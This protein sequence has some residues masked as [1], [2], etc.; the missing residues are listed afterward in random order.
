MSDEITTTKV[1]EPLPVVHHKGPHDTD[2]SMFTQAADRLERGFPLGGGNLT[3]AVVELIR[4]EVVRS[5]GRLADDRPTLSDDDLREEA[6]RRGMTVVDAQEWARV[7]DGGDEHHTLDELYE[8]RM[9]YN[10]HAAQGWLAAGIPVVKSHRHSDGE[11]CFG[12]GWFIVVATLPTGQAANH[13]RDEFWGLFD[14]PEVDLPPEYDGH[15]PQDAA[16]RLR[17]LL[18]AADEK[19]Q[20]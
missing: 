16:D 3:R 14:V 18:S 10:A 12:G 20:R 17:T 11:P 9:L 4:R 15:T 7:R 2:A 13:Y 5:D 6:A 1:A 8:Y 19:A